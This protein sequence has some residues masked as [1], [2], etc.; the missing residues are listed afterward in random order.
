[1]GAINVDGMLGEFKR[2]KSGH[3]ITVFVIFLAVS[4]FYLWFLTTSKTNTGF[5]ELYL[6][7][8][9]LGVLLFPLH[10]FSYIPQFK[11]LPFGMIGFGNTEKKIRGIPM[12][13]ISLALGGFFG[14]VV[15]LGKIIQPVKAACINCNGTLV[16]VTLGSA[17]METV[18][19]SGLIIPTLYLLYLYLGISSFMAV[20][21]LFAVFFLKLELIFLLIIVALFL[22]L[23][24]GARPVYN[25]LDSAVK[26]K[27]AALLLALLTS[28]FLF[29]YVT[30]ASASVT[31]SDYTNNMI[32]GLIMDSTSVVTGS[33]AGPVLFHSIVNGVMNEG[34]SGWW[35]VAPAVIFIISMMLAYPKRKG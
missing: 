3:E 7:F 23:F 13:V 22:W 14:L 12:P 19:F 25:G 15:M 27:A 1:M 2:K 16:P 20:L 21:V 32:A 28:M 5:S 8:M 9:V 4:L 11:D 30:H 10:L 24:F 18:N 33:I 26:T 17:I 31:R 35:W 34:L 6:P 29:A